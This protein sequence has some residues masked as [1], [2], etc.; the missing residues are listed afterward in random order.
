MQR[1]MLFIDLLFYLI[2]EH[3]ANI[4]ERGGAKGSRHDFSHKIL[5]KFWNK[6]IEIS[7]LLYT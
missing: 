5:F 7:F 3:T 4:R 6:Q 2:L 1:K